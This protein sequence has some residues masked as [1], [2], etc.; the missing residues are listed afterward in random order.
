MEDK[1]C[2]RFS[3][4][5]DFFHLLFTF[6]GCVVML[7]ALHRARRTRRNNSYCPEKYKRKMCIF[8]INGRPCSVLFFLKDDHI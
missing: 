3:L 2:L 1:V 8:Y 5:A 4:D 6:C 7:Y